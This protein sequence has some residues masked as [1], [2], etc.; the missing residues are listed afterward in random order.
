M[1]SWEVRLPW[2]IAESGERPD[3]EPPP[4]RL[5][6][7]V[8]VDRLVLAWSVTRT[9]GLLMAVLFRES[10]H[11]SGEAW[12]AGASVGWTLG[13]VRPFLKAGWFHAS[14]DGS[15]ETF[16]GPR[17]IQVREDGVFGE[18]GLR[19]FLGEP[20]ALRAG[21]ERFDFELEDD[22]AFT[23]GAEIRF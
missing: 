16:A 9:F 22:G 19:V 12:S 21:Y 10:R 23:L 14:T 15:E 13:R 8:H 1:N 20:V 6:R 2:E 11:L 17:T 7:V 5:A 4:V 3:H 18:A